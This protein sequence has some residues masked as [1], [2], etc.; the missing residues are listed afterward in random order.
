MRIVVGG[1]SGL[2]GT[3]LVHRLREAGH[4]VVRLVRR[5]PADQD[6]VQW[7][8]NQ[9]DLD[10]TVLDGADAAINL[11]GA[12]AGDQRWTPEYK[13]LLRTSRVN[14]T[15]ALA[16][17]L[18]R[19]A[20]PPKVLVNASAV[21]YYGDT[22]DTEIDERA[23]AGEGFFPELCQA[24]EAATVPAAEA[25]VRVVL[26]RTGLV[27]TRE[28][29]LLKP[30]LP[31]FRFGLG[32]RWGH[33]RFWMP[34]VTL[35]DQVRAVEFLLTADGVSGAVNVCGPAP[36][37]NADFARTLGKVLH[38]P[39]VLPVPAFALRIVAGEFANEALTSLRVRSSRLSDAGFSYT[40]PDLVAGLRWAVRH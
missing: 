17:A 23:P 24:W 6:E 16:G 15:E 32:G 12:G 26:I 5:E 37:R 38:R 29:G 31:L 14:A 33:G 35:L 13:N 2:I 7:R 20:D 11:A 3:L 36:V 8:P 34:W 40:H 10:P 28:G 30:V 19:A 9:E 27:L 22:G 39:A 4:R 1:S 18:A 21:G 25:G